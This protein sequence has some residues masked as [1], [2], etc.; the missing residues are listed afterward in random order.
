MNL[1]AA[2]AVCRPADWQRI[3]GGDREL[4]VARADG[5][6]SIHISAS[7]IEGGGAGLK[8]RAEK[9]VFLDQ[10]IRGQFDRPLKSTGAPAAATVG[11]LTGRAQTGTARDGTKLYIFAAVDEGIVRSVVMRYPPEATPTVAAAVNTVAF[12][13][14]GLP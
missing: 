12:L 14:T 13:W 8:A 10:F 5:S 7:R 4:A 9:D 1:A 11:G 3:E 6:A 2:A